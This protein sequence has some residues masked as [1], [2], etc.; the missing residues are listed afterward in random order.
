LKRIHIFYLLPLLLLPHAMN[1]KEIKE[2]VEKPVGE[3]ITINQKTQENEEEWRILREKLTTQLDSL[4]LQV[5]QLTT[6]RNALKEELAQTKLRISKKTQKLEAIKHI[7]QQMEPFLKDLVQEVV[8]LPH[9]H[10]PFLMKERTLRM[11]R[12]E[13]IMN[14]PE[15][16]LS[17]KYRKTMETLHIE[18]E[19][20]FTIESSQE[21]IDIDN[22]KMLVNTFRLG[23]T[24]LYYV[25]L[26][27]RLCGFYNLAE[28]KWSPLP[29]K[30][31]K[32]LLTAVDIADKRRPVE[33]VNMPLGRMVIK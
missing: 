15:I 14:D 33:F 12:L 20:G 17:E 7:E 16:S 19:F 4:Q 27:E 2:K 1:A 25:T 30:F 6:K 24:G 29:K 28:K 22:Q 9:Q 18:A 13:K 31:I 10:L 21:T 5:D 3:A 32:P 26:D 8:N 11:S 23:R